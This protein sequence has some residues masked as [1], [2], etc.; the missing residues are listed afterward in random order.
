[1]RFASDH[2]N[3]GGYTRGENRVRQERQHGSVRKVSVTGT[4]PRP[5]ELPLGP[6][7]ALLSMNHR[8]FLAKSRAGREGDGPHFAC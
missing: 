2:P 5:S 6:E 1:V 4:L 7:L 8:E 3:F